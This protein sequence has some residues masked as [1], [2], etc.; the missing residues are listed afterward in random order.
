M[1]A[2][3]WRVGKSRRSVCHGFVYGAGLQQTMCCALSYTPILVVFVCVASSIT[4]CTQ[5]VIVLFGWLVF[6]TVSLWGPFCPR[7]QESPSL[8]FLSGRIKDVRHRLCRLL[9][10]KSKSSIR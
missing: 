3:L 4:R 2:G 10:L 9:V 1:S 7:T 5:S 8:C 6:E